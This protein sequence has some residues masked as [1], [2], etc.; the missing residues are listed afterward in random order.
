MRRKSPPVPNGISA[1]LACG[2]IALAVVEE[3]VDHLVDRAVAADRDDP[4][5]AAAQRLARELG[6]IA[7]ALGMHVVERERAAEGV[8][9]L[10]PALPEPPALRLRD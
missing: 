2:A 9:E 6:R 3:S 8:R 7:R 5:R 10:G 1:K 4:L